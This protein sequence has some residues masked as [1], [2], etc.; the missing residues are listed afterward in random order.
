MPPRTG[1]F[2]RILRLN[3]H[4]AHVLL[5]LE[6]KQRQVNLILSF[7]WMIF[8]RGLP[9]TDDHA[10]GSRKRK[11]D[12]ITG[13][14]TI[15]LQAGHVMWSRR[16]SASRIEIL[17]WTIQSIHDRLCIDRLMHMSFSSRGFSV[18]SDSFMCVLRVIKARPCLDSTPRLQFQKDTSE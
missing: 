15:A 9:L 1:S 16:Y 7:L 12:C 18:S 2:R 3:I 13:T 4:H 6:A 8:Q 10:V 14:N 11:V 5:T 17:F